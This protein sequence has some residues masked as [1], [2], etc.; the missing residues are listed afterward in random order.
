MSWHRST[1]QVSTETPIYSYPTHSVAAST[2][3]NIL[4]CKY[5]STYNYATV[6]VDRLLDPHFQEYCT[7]FMSDGGEN[8]QMFCLTRFL[9]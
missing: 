6:F 3:S 1:T 5:M 7:Y 2:S 8:F 4:V 9:W